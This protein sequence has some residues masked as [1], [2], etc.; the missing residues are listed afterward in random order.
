M[1]TRTATI[2]S[3]V[4]LHA[5]P[6]KLFVDKVAAAGT[7]VTIGRPGGRTVNAASMLGV[8]SLGAKH[9]DEVELTS[10]DDALLEELV[11]FLEVDHDE[12]K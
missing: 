1:S 9:G 10:D 3:S 6:A 2:A 8:M 4:G 5:R 11:A 7:S 12:V